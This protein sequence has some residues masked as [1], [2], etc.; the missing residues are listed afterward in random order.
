MLRVELDDSSASFN[1]K[2]RTAITSKIPNIWIIGEREAE[3]KK[4]TWR[5]YGHEDQ[6]EMGADDAVGLLAK[7]YRERTMDNFEDVKIN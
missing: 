7:L 6:F 1:K 3:E 4:V 5:R 2:I